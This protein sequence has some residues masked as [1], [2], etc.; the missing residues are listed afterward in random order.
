MKNHAIH[1]AQFWRRTLSAIATIALL[2]ACGAGDAHQSDTYRDVDGNLTA[3]WVWGGAEPA[4]ID[5]ILARIRSASGERSNPDQYDT[6]SD[7]G[8]GH[9]TYEFVAV[10][11]AEFERGEAAAQ[12]GNTEA[13]FDAFYTAST[14][15]QIAKFPF[16]R[17]EDYPHFLAAYQSSMAAYERAGQYLDVP[18]E[19]VEI[20]YETGKIRGYLH[21]TSTALE[22]PAPIVFISGGIDTFKVEHYP[23]VKA[24]NEA[25][26][27]ALVVDLPGVG[28]SNFVE[29]SFEHDQVYSAFLDKVSTDPRIDG[30]RAGVW[31]TSWGGNAAARLAFTDERFDAV[32]SACGPI[33][34]ALAI[35]T[36]VARISPNTIRGSVP[37]VVLDVVTDRLGLPSPLQSADTVQ[38]TKRIRKFSLI[39]Q[40]FVNG[41]TRAA[42]PVLAINTDD[43]GVAPPEDLEA[44]IASAETGEL[45]FTG[46]GGHCGSRIPIVAK[47]VP[48]L[49]SYLVKEDS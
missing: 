38:L 36:W 44:L 25:G 9:W 4:M 46:S 24:L 40:G 27:S 49:A 23:M 18:L 35:P 28:E 15:Y 16:I 8:P 14:Y 12:L 7:Y 39:E 48:W 37:P 3:R 31:A 21:L 10:A 41:E 29:A 6:I 13:A 20:P 17:N 1:K 2:T 34:E 47:S 22:R 45:V 33:H 26:M 11:D 42:V 30:N 5:S 32:V 43:D 19:I